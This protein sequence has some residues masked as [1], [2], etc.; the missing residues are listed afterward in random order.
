[1]SLTDEITS[2]IVTTYLPG[3][4]PEELDPSYDLLETGVVDS[5]R[6]VQLVGWVAETYRIPLD[7]LDISADHF[8]SVSSITAFVAVAAGHRAAGL[9]PSDPSAN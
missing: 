5:L 2:H 3:T 4:A 8:R 9:G 6:L 1:M 7:E